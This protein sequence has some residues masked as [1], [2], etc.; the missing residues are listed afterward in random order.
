MVVERRTPGTELIDVLD[1]VLDKGI[2][3]DPSMRISLVGLDLL[4]V[5]LRVVV[6]SIETYLKHFDALALTNT[7][8]A[9]ASPRDKSVPITQVTPVLETAPSIPKPKVR[10]KI[11]PA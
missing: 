6:A 7:A 8:V 11:G 2:V 3:I 1:R 4:S 5:D 10:G 9:P